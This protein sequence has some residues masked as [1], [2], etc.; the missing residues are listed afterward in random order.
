MTCFFVTEG[1]FGGSLTD[2]V[3]GSSVIIVA[4]GFCS[5]QMA[6]ALGRGELQQCHGECS[7]GAVMGRFA[8]IDLEKQKEEKR[9]GKL[10]HENLS[11]SQSPNGGRE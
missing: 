7:A 6:N 2:K 8:N 9:L 5:S 1:R 11:C 4:Q 3:V 10:K